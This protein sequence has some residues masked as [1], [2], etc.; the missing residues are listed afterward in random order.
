MGCLSAFADWCARCEA[1]LVRICVC[2]SIRYGQVVSAFPTAEEQ[3]QCLAV[4]NAGSRT[5]CV[6]VHE[7]VR[8]MRETQLVTKECER[9]HKRTQPQQQGDGRDGE[10]RRVLVH[11][12]CRQV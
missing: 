9:S 11:S 5:S 3:N 10:G 7:C 4:V 6:H 1:V 2:K 8:V 12:C